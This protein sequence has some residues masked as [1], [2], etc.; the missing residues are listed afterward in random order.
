[1]ATMHEITIGRDESELLNYLEEFDLDYFRKSY[2]SATSEEERCRVDDLFINRWELFE[3]SDGQSEKLFTKKLE[4]Q[5]KIISQIRGLP[6]PIDRKMEILN[7]HIEFMNAVSSDVIDIHGSKISRTTLI[8]YKWTQPS[9]SYSALQA[10][11]IENVIN[12][13]G[14]VTYSFLFY[15]AYSVI[16]IG[17]K[18]SINV[19][20]MRIAY[21]IAQIGILLISYVYILNRISR[22]RQKTNRKTISSRT[23]YL[24]SWQ[25]FTRWDYLI[26][27]ANSASEKKQSI[28]TQFREYIG[29][30]TE[31]DKPSRPL[32]IHI[33]MGIIS[34]FLVLLT[35]ISCGAA[36]LLTLRA[37]ECYLKNTNN[38]IIRYMVS[39]VIAGSNIVAPFLFDLFAKIE[40][41]KAGTQLKLKLFRVMVMYLLNMSVLMFTLFGLTPVAGTAQNPLFC[42]NVT[43]GSSNVSC[44]E[45]SVGQELMKVSVI[46]LYAVFVGIFFEILRAAF[47]RSFPGLRDGT[48]ENPPPYPEFELAKSVLQLIYSQGLA[49]IVVSPDCG[50]Y[51]SFVGMT[52][53]QIIDDFVRRS[54]EGVRTFFEYITQTFVIIPLIILLVLIVIYF[55]DLSAS[56]K[57][58]SNDLR[59]QLQKLTVRNTYLFHILTVQNKPYYGDRYRTVSYLDQDRIHVADNKLGPFSYHYLHTE[60]L[61]K[62]ELSSN[63]IRQKS[64]V[65]SQVAIDGRYLQS[66]TPASDQQDSENLRSSLQIDFHSFG[67]KGSALN[68]ISSGE[69]LSITPP[70]DTPNTTVDETQI[71][72]PVQA[73]QISIT[74]N[75]SLSLTESAMDPNRSG[76]NTKTELAQAKTSSSSH[77]LNDLMTRMKNNPSDLTREEMQRVLNSLPTNARQAVSEMYYKYKAKMR[78]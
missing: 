20:D 56:Y 76:E 13:Q 1:M 8:L 49:C 41:Y 71:S 25:L 66:N 38:I 12:F 54:P 52:L 40:N 18:N 58:L 55:R 63:A 28:K 75:R 5:H 73:N 70:F 2:L 14:P 53:Y 26:T 19:Y 69:R 21:F 68:D 17:T 30:V 43:I 6:W 36:I 78:K 32:I 59:V 35:W 31:R 3:Y 10:D 77:S 7:K 64:K 24:F 45:T 57:T 47:V 34:N 62:R 67:G 60:K 29:D 37:Y 50:P 23:N 46:D 61:R 48:I 27:S 39:L 44:W 65:S 16:P 72:E 74:T 22:H 33:I 11:T 15:G 9:T 51:R 42:G 4:I